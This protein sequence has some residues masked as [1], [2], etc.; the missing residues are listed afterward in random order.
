M[1]ISISKYIHIYYIIYYYNYYIIYI[2]IGRIY[3]RIYK[4]LCVY[5][6]IRLCTLGYQLEISCALLKHHHRTAPNPWLMNCPI[7]DI[8]I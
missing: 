1:C 4:H 3:A 6:Y 5:I 2:L 8:P 7:M